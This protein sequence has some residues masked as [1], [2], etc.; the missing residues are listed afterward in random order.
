MAMQFSIYDYK[1]MFLDG[2]AAMADSNRIYVGTTQSE[3]EYA[4][5]RPRP[6]GKGAAYAEGG[7]IATPYVVEFR[8]TENEVN[9]GVASPM[10]FYVLGAR[11]VTDADG[12]PLFNADGSPVV[13]T[14][15]TVVGQLTV[16]EIED[17]TSYRVAVSS[18]RYKWFKVT[19]T[20]GRASAFLLRG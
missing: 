5:L 1:N 4:Y 7:D 13:P 18:N 19:V 20:G 14:D 17:T 3:T 6:A 8:V 9:D 12:K 16:P 11:A 2:S 15:F 10:T